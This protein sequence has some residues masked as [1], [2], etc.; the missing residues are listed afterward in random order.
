MKGSKW[1]YKLCT[2][3]SEKEIMVCQGP[4]FNGIFYF[5][6]GYVKISYEYKNV[7]NLPVEH[8]NVLVR[9]FFT[10]KPITQRP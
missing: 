6:C 1:N 8:F 7:Q 2:S 9:E 5:Y 3:L 4:N 10:L